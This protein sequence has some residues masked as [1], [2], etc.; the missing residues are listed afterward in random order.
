M[1]QRAGK[2]G[3]RYL[4]LLT[5]RVK[6]PISR[7]PCVFTPLRLCVSS[8]AFFRMICLLR[9]VRDTIEAIEDARTIERVKLERKLAFVEEIVMMTPA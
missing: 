6:V 5:Q 2:W 4:N 8:P 1:R 7:N 9:Q 3:G